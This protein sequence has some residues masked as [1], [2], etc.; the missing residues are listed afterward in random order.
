MNKRWVDPQSLAEFESSRMEWL[1]LE[2]RPKLKL[3]STA[4]ASEAP[5]ATLGQ[6]GD[7][8]AWRISAAKGAAASH[9]ASP[10]ME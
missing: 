9:T 7:E 3:I 4:T 10:A 2:A 1:G 6:V 5:I 8:A